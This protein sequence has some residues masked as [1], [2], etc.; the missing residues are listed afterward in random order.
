MARNEVDFWV[1]I[2]DKNAKVPE[3]KKSFGDRKE[4]LEIMEGIQGYSLFDSDEIDGLE[5][6]ITKMIERAAKG[7]FRIKTVDTAQLRIKYFFG[8]GYS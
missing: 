1:D 4:Q 7:K 8:Y 3:H 2:F 5:S 6:N